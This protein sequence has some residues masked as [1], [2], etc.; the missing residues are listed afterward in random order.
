[1]RL[2]YSCLFYSLIPFIVL[3]L[4]WRSAKAPAYR[5]RWRERFA[6]YTQPYPAHTFWFHAVSVGEAESLFPLIKR[7]QQAYPQAK[8]LVTTTTPTGSAR[9]IAT[10]AD[11][12][13]HVYLPYDLPD[14]T[15]R[16]MRCFKPQVAV[17]METE[18]WPN[19]FACC[20]KKNVPLVI[21]NARLSEKSA[22]G[23]RRIPALVRPT[24]AHVKLI[25]TQTPEDRLRFMAI[26]AAGDTVTT[27]GN[28]KF[29]VETP[30]ALIAQGLEVK[31]AL[32]A[33]RFVWLCASTHEGEEAIVLRLYQQLKPNIPEL[34]LLI[35]PR[36]P[37]RFAPVKKLCGR[38]Q[39]NSVTRTS[40]EICGTDVDVYLLDTLGEL[41]LFYGAADAAFVGGSLV[42]VGGHNILEAAAVGVPVLFG[43]YMSNF[44]AI[45]ES[46]VRQ[47]AA[48]QC[49]T[50]A[51]IS[52][53]VMALYADPAYRAAMIAK[54]K[55]FVQKNQGATTRILTLL[56]QMSAPYC[57]TKL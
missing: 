32:F 9:V 34:L 57:S 37:E 54:G 31:S 44:K 52:Q 49:L 28:I 16:F 51:D 22:R 7:I 42:P 53:A 14:A 39:L 40:G 3:R 47:G 27:A 48:L 17:I 29:D 24:L 5:K 25:A 38:Q 55:A 11:T 15:S 43:P 12:V 13:T 30:D 19:L 23:Y 41:K 26:G 4:L 56:G 6:C 35:A 20:G 10:L 33:G 1:M 50:E 21:I 36:H 8:L 18:I 46:S 2:F 45:A